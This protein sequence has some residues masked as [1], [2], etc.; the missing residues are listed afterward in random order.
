M[1]KP[2]RNIY[3]YTLDALDKY[4]RTNAL[5]KEKGLGWE[6]GVKPDDI[7]FCDDIGENLKA[8]KQVG[9]RT[10]KV[11]LGRTYEAVDEL[12]DITGLKLAG[13]H[14]RIPVKPMVRKK[15]SKKS[16]VKL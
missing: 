15:S 13:D 16:E 14:P 10:I 1:R 11:N 5:S 6:A 3:E 7:I 2:D 8:A 9:F 4:A 12:E